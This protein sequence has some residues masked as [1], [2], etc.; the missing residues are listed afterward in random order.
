MNYY[1]RHIG[2]Y[3][4][5]TSHLS[6]LEHG[7]Y[8][9]LLDIYYTREGA[10]PLDQAERLVGAR[11]RDERAAV[12]RVLAEFFD[13]QES[14]WVQ[15]RC[16]REIHIAQVKAERNREVGKKGGRPRTHGLENKPTENPDGF[17]K[18]PTDNPSHKPIANS[19]VEEGRKAPSRQ[20]PDGIQAQACEVLDYLNVKAKKSF[21]RAEGTLKPI[22]ARLAEGEPVATL[23]RVIDAKVA[24]WKGDPKMDEYLRPSTLFAP[25]KYAGYAGN[26]PSESSGVPWWARRGYGTKEMALQAGL[27]EPA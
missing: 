19:Q 20:E 17:Q 14:G 25:E 22:R 26:L 10:L 21:R 13:K 8:T 3:L 1:R 24:V 5:D 7:V 27:R 15:D 11:S 23:K 16:E 18:E 9:R 4:R 12:Q 2:D 6:L